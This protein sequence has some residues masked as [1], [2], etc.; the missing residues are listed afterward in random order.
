MF[1]LKRLWFRSTNGE[2]IASFFSPLNGQLTIKRDLK[3][4]RVV[5]GGLTQ[6]GGQVEVLW[7]QA[8]KFLRKQTPTFL[9]RNALLLGLGGGSNAELVSRLWP[10]V[11]I[12][13]VEIDPVMVEIGRKYFKLNQINDLAVEISDAVSYVLD[14]A[15]SSP[16]KFDLILVDLYVGRD[17]PRAAGAEIF[18][19][20]IGSLL[21]SGGRVVFNRLN[22]GAQAVDFAALV[23]QFFTR[24]E[25]KKIGGNILIFAYKQPKVQMVK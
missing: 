25:E 16:G 11:K 8:L 3:G 19:Q 20:G 14:R 15:K 21:S 2:T 23:S 4:F 24:V 6:S 9:P 18:L 22:Y 12:T 13:A 7:K 5:A 10:Q 1:F 17:Y